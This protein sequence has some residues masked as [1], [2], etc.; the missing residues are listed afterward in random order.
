[1]FNE[2]LWCVYVIG[3]VHCALGKL[4]TYF[5][6]LLVFSIVRFGLT[7]LGVTGS[8]ITVLVDWA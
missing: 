5:F 1:M 7:L 4:C 6:D 3:R 8:D 2:V